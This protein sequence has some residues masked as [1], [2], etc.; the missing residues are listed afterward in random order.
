MILDPPGVLVLVMTLLMLV[1]LLA[2]GLSD[3]RSRQSSCSD[4]GA[5]WRRKREGLERLGLGP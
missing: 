3:R 4:A 1:P 5:W 2:L